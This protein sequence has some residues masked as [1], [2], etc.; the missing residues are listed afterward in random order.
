[1]LL[2]VITPT[3]QAD[4]LE[5]AYQSLKLQKYKNWEWVIAPNNDDVVIPA[6]IQRDPRVRVVKESMS[7]YNIGAIKR[8]AFDTA[9][10]DVFIE[11]DHDD[12]LRP[13]DTLGSIQRAAKDGG[14]FIYSDNAVFRYRAASSRYSTPWP[15]YNEYTFSGEHGWESYPVSVYGRAF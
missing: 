9:L 8:H 14:G 10:G 1:M 5:E 2:S 12:M 11:L 4:Y 3:H 15:L 6:T 7:D 13:A